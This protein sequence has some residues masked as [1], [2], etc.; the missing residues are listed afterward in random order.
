MF[1]RWLNRERL[2]TNFLPASTPPFSSND[3][4]AP[5]PFGAYRFAAAYQGLDG[6]P[7]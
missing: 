6:R 1:A 7:A 4:T 3:T 2:S 5:T